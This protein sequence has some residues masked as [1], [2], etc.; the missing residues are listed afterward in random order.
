MTQRVSD[1]K[2]AQDKSFD[3]CMHLV[4]FS[5]KDPFVVFSKQTLHKLHQW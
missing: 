5:V 3:S 4:D 1:S 2:S